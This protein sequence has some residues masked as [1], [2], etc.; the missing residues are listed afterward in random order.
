MKTSEPSR[1]RLAAGFGGNPPVGRL[2]AAADAAPDAAPAPDSPPTDS[3]TSV[4]L[5]GLL[6]A[7]TF[8]PW[9]SE[10]GDGVIAGSGRVQG[11]LVCIWAQDVSH[12]GGS[13]GSAGGE[14]ISRTIRHASRVGVPVIGLPHSGGARLQEGVAALGAYG[15]IFRE[16]ALSR[17]PQIT[18][19]PGACAGGAAYSPALGDFVIMV[20][21]QS[22]L[23]L[24]GPKVVE[25]VTREQIS[26][27]DLGGPRVHSANGV[28]HLV[29]DD[30]HSAAE[31][32][33]AVL[34]YIPS[35]F[36]G[37][38][39]LVP[40]VDPPAGSPADRL[41]ASTRHVYDV[42]DVI[43]L[44]VDGGRHLELAPRWAR[45]MVTTFAHFDGRPV[46]VIANQPRHL[47]GTIDSAA[48]E[49]GR[50]FVDLC[51]RFTL[52]LVVLVDTPGFLPGA[53]QEQAGVI[54]HGASL[55]RAFARAT[56]P[57]ITVTLRQAY[58]GAHIV[59][60]SRDLGADLTLAWPRAQIGV[61]GAS[62]AVAIAEHRAIADGA[63]AVRL[64]EVY[65]SERLGVDVAAASGFVDEVVPPE[66]TRDRLIRALE[67]HV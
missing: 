3:P 13:L 47:G 20:S 61:M 12:R 29:T 23:F 51:D 34:S 11:R 16:Q 60:N 30:D 64:A 49:K 24:T 58:G 4:R 1:S 2:E 62:Q 37:S 33:R 32:L 35:T 42:R 54:R 40:P 22:R 52:P 25:Q 66:K 10:V 26:A 27:E 31:L 56:T 65:A 43:Q 14:T 50:W 19:I 9:R 28:A 7:D 17:V 5:Q 45:N 21:P 44:L 6:D 41:P 15:A 53:H 39:P 38:M 57:K 18:M 63:D 67:L 55:L 59:M 36:G 46:G 8:R 48:S